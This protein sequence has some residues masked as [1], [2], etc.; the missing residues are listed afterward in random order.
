MR[1]P[2]WVGRRRASGGAVTSAPV[3]GPVVSNAPY[4]AVM[5]ALTLA[6]CY[7]DPRD[8]TCEDWRNLHHRHHAMTVALFERGL[9]RYPPDPGK[10]AG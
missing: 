8:G 10:V 4:L 5:E 2:A 3:L 6:D 7:C 9:I 1:L